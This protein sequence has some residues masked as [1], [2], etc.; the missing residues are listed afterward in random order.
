[1]VIKIQCN[2]YTLIV[3]FGKNLPDIFHEI[4]YQCGP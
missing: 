1:M 3:I 4:K 2:L